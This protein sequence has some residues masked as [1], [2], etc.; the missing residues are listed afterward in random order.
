MDACRNDG[1]IVFTPYGPY[2]IVMMNKN[3]SDAI[4]YDEH[5]AIVFGAKISRMI[6][7]QFLALEGRLIL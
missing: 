2:V 6:L 5:P 3:F 4:Y 7:D 1:G